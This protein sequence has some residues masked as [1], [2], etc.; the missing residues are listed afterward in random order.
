MGGYALACKFI[1]PQIGIRQACG[2]LAKIPSTGPR[3]PKTISQA[4]ETG[5]HPR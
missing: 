1:F 3:P 2:C 4:H 5:K